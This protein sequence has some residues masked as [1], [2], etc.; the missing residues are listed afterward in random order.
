MKARFMKTIGSRQFTILMIVF[1]N[2]LGASMILP[3]LP[4]YARRHFDLDP[5]FITTI[6][7]SFFAAQFIAGP[8][9][10]RLSDHYGRL[11]I[12]IIS[13]I[14]TVISFI[15]LG[16]AQ[17]VEILFLAR[18]LD[19]I[20]G[21]NIIVAQ[22]YITDVMPP[23]KRTQ[24]LGYI[25][26]AFGLGFVFGPA[27][28]GIL[29]AAFGERIPF[30][31]AALA[32]TLTV[33]LT[34]FTLDESL[35]P[36]QRLANRNFKKASLKPREIWQNTPLVLILVI[37]FGGQFGLGLLQST[38]ALFGEAV[39]FKGQTEQA[40]N[41]G[42]GLLLGSV[43][44][45]QLFTQ[46]YLLKKVLPMYGEA[47][48]AIGG[49][50][51]RGLAML[52]VSLMVSPLLAVLGTIPFAIGTG[53]MMPSLQSLTTRTVADELR[54]G[55]LGVYQSSISLSTI[56]ATAI[57]GTLFEI[58]PRLPYWV[59]AILFGVMGIQALR[60][61]NWSQLQIAKHPQVKG[62]EQA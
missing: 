59:G 1:V 39:I 4:L 52:T 40:T 3:I 41:L 58:N 48:L 31:I 46:V 49:S 11:P 43:G 36:A 51:I 27:L 25:F 13:Q 22:A 54:G 35:T 24:A 28:G 7:A 38:F 23:E 26:A 56:I 32:A 53:L 44:L 5:R 9:L 21:G 45:G 37:A 18:V 34:W 19:G 60:L 12:L 55:V 17:T 2:I 16:M 62:A 6:N 50:F 61:L 57:S 20:T 42:I 30:L 29:S 33:L 8:Y 15:M 47:R 10:G 14:G